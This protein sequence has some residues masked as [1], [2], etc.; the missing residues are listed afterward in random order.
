VVAVSFSFV[1]ALLD[2]AL[3]AVLGEP[4]QGAT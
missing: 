4:A 1:N 2:K 3:Q